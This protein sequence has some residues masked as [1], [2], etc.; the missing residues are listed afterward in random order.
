MRNAKILAAVLTLKTQREPIA[1]PPTAPAPARRQHARQAVQRRQP[2]SLSRNMTLGPRARCG[3]GRQS[4]APW[5]S[6]ATQP[7]D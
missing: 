2:C 3:R 1:G 7:S 6:A 4:P 5:A